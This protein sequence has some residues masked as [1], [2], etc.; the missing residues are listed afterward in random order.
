MSDSVTPS[1][2][3]EAQ[4]LATAVERWREEIRDLE[5]RRDAALQKLEAAIRLLDLVKGDGLTA[6]AATHVPAPSPPRLFPEI[7]S[8]PVEVRGD[9]P[10]PDLVR[11]WVGAARDGLSYHDLRTLIE[12]NPTI[13]AR[14]ATSDKGYY[15]ALSRLVNRNEL[16]RHNGRLFT[17]EAYERYQRS[18]AAG[19][20]EDVPAVQG[21]AYSPMGE[22]V[23]DIV[24]LHRTAGIAGKD[25]INLLKTDPEF[26]ATL[27]PHTSGAYNVISRLTKRNQIL[28]RDDGLCFPGARFQPRKA[29]SKWLQ[30]QGVGTM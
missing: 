22:A 15:N 13:A 12:A 28:R 8:R 14:F 7:A 9:A 17:S 18:V 5:G 27:T 6:M 23:L 3:T 2:V 1:S 30:G 25:I 19:V 16:A 20:I 24:H 21:G 29:D 26:N 4:F 11:Q 10:W